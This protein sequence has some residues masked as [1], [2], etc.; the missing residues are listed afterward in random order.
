M[1]FNP[2]QDFWRFIN[3]PTPRQYA[4]QV[5]DP[6]LYVNILFFV[7]FFVNI[8]VLVVVNI[9]LIDS[10]ELGGAFDELDFGFWKMFGLAVVGAPLVEEIIFRGPL[11][12]KLALTVL[13]ALLI[14]VL[15]AAM[16]VGSGLTELSYYVSP[17]LFSVLLL[18]LLSMDGLW[19]KWKLQIDHMYPYLFFLV[20]GVFGF[21]HIYNYNQ[22]AFSW[23]MVPILIMPQFILA[24]FLGFVRLRVGLWAC[25]YMHALNNLIPTLLFFQ[26]DKLVE[27]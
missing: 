22:D 11:R 1:E 24:L 4:E 13:V 25:I 21:V 19:E 17:I 23:W 16:L 15:M 20:A 3:H 26:M 14:S 18:L 7:A 8:I 12:N 6:F 27:G 2:L 5:S 10:S 9:L